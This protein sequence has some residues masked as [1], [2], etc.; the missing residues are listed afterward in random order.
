MWAR[1]FGAIEKLENEHHHLASQVFLYS[2]P[3]YCALQQDLVRR[4]GHGRRA[5]MTHRSNSSFP[6]RPLHTAL[7]KTAS[8]HLTSPRNSY[9]ASYT[10]YDGPK[11]PFQTSHSRDG[12][13][14]HCCATP[15]RTDGGDQTASE[16]VEPDEGGAC[17]CELVRMIGSAR[18]WGRDVGRIG[19]RIA[20][21]RG[22]GDTGSAHLLTLDC[23]Y[24]ALDLA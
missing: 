21:T 5:C 8:R 6:K 16:G 2:A 23:S 4:P 7:F 18:L 14:L 24:S 17:G 1:W 19:R 15:T 22:T 20:V 13:D 3:I 11:N 10:T 9:H 12:L